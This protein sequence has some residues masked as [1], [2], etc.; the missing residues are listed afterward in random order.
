MLRKIRKKM[1][2]PVLNQLSLIAEQLNAIEEK[3]I[4][5]KLP[6]DDSVPRD[7]LRSIDIYDY[8]G[9]KLLLDN[10]S[11][12]DWHIINTDAW[13]E[14]QIDYFT[15]L[16][17]YPGAERKIFLDIGAY[18]G[19]YSLLAWKSNLFNEIYAFEADKYNYSQLQANLFLTG[20][21]DIIAVNKLVSDKCGVVRTFPSLCH[22][23]G[24]RGG[25]GVWH[26]DS[27]YPEVDSISIDSYFS[28][29][30]GG[31]IYVKIDVEAHEIS[32]LN[33]MKRL[34]QNNKV[35]LQVEAIGEKFEEELDAWVSDNNLIKIR[36]ICHDYFITNILDLH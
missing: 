6:K 19:L 17:D 9:L 13:E 16:W 26:D 21:A 25:V 12:V 23:D 18:F 8:R 29:V 30:E 22:P 27:G 20:S 1:L 28:S 5:Q 3:L 36:K 2:N 4:E 7:K 34:I 32:V 10:K 31:I 14:E 24:N 33:G 11:S 35:V 15:S